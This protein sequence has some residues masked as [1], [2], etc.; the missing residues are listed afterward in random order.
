MDQR[1]VE[2]AND[3]AS[4]AIG[5]TPPQNDEGQMTQYMHGFEQMA[6]DTVF[7]QFLTC[8]YNRSAKTVNANMSDFLKYLI[9]DDLEALDRKVGK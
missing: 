3:F 9:N 1:V 8:A 7:P 2:G 6:V 5:E 4:M